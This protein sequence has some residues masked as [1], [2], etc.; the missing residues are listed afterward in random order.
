MK[1]ASFRRSMMAGRQLLAFGSELQSL[2]PK[3]L[4]VICTSLGINAH[5]HQNS[6]SMAN[7]SRCTPSGG[8]RREGMQEAV[9][10]QGSVSARQD[11][12]GTHI[13][14]LPACSY[15]PGGPFRHPAQHASG[16]PPALT[17]R[18][19]PRTELTE[20]CAPA[21]TSGAIKPG[22]P[23]TPVSGTMRDC[24]GLPCCCKRT[25]IHT[26]VTHRITKLR[27]VQRI[28]GY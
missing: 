19:R 6:P 20:C 24:P 12:W 26:R 18:P 7:W 17:P 15:A 3:R 10:Q 21:T 1:V 25:Y 11:L 5:T 13:C 27:G 2:A 9:R 23:N 14:L 22:E 28:C 4:V 16:V 8:C